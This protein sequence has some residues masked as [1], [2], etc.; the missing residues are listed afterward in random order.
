MET[1][2]V[3]DSSNET[4]WRWLIEWVHSRAE[5]ADASVETPTVSPNLELKTCLGSGD[6]RGVVCTR[7]IPRGGL[8]IRLPMCMAVHGKSMPESYVHDGAVR[9]VSTWLRCLAAWMRADQ[10][11]RSQSES[12]DEPTTNSF[13][14]KIDSF[15][16]YIASLPNTYETLWA[17]SDTEL[18]EFLAGT[19]PPKSSV[20]PNSTYHAWSMHSVRQSYEDRIRPYL[21]F[22]ALVDS[23]TAESES[24][25]QSFAEAC[26][27]MS[28]RSFYLDEMDND[29]RPNE[30]N[31]SA[32][33]YAGPYLLPVMDLINHARGDSTRAKS[34]PD[35]QTPLSSACTSVQWVNGQFCMMA[36]RNIAVGEEI[37]HSYGDHLCSSQFLATY[38]FVPHEL[39][40]RA[41][42][43][44]IAGND[45]GN[46][47]NPPLSP[48]ILEK[49]DVFDCC[50]CIVASTI[51]EQIANDMKADGMEDE[52]WVVTV[53]RSRTAGYVPD[54]IIVWHPSSVTGAARRPA[55]DSA[56]R[57][58]PDAASSLLS[59]ELVTAA[60]VPFLPRCAYAEIT[61][62]TLLDR[63][64]L[65]DYFLGKLVGMALLEAVKRRRAA[66]RPISSTTQA[67][68]CGNAAGGD[69]DA[70]LLQSLLLLLSKTDGN[71]ESSSERTLR[72]ERARLAYGLSVRIEEKRML[73]ALS[74]EII[75]YMMNL[76]DGSGTGEVDDGDTL[77]QDSAP[78]SKQQ[79]IL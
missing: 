32:N 37:L 38:G 12:P 40:Q 57:P 14:S 26:Q 5:M 18:D 79:R 23:S 55:T 21:V 9:P 65:E 24:E 48:V 35:Q 78:R 42:T 43:L 64:I 34:P 52:T 60:C 54:N 50:W 7:A 33:S 4:V 72:L 2:W 44:G 31:E 1:Q 28:T 10:S 74:Q 76:D 13:Q 6:Y 30:A 36:E 17:W 39:L 66:Y 3:S 22:C 47:A 61:R 53:D 71:D 45:L 73:E 69:C 63:S 70:S 49:S 58:A 56:R 8:L 59:D 15:A 46:A 51:P 11:A 62:R 67:R 77:Q 27:I 29:D 19:R 16:P 68:L 25:F 41:A 75:A 20:S